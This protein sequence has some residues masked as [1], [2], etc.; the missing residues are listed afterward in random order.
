MNTFPT[1]RQLDI[2]RTVLSLNESKHKAPTTYM[3]AAELKMTNRG[4]K[5]QLESLEGKGLIASD[6]PTTRTG[7]PDVN[8]NRARRWRVTP[9]GMAWLEAL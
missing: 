9:Q 8:R 1:S 2:M 7:A 6:G 5:G 4:A 3:L